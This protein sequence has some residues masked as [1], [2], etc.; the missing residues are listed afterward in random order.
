MDKDN[1]VST[2]KDLSR[3]NNEEAVRFPMETRF[4]PII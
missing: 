4:I 3:M 1:A 2:G